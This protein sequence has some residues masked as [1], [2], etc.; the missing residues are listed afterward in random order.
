LRKESH[1]LEK[2]RMNGGEELQ[3]WRMFQGTQLGSVL[4]GIYGNKQKVN[5]PIPKKAKNAFD[6]SKH[7]F[8]PVN[9]PVVHAPQ[10]PRKTT[11]RDISNFHVPTGFHGGHSQPS[12][13]H[14]ISII[15]HRKGAAEIRAEMEEI[16]ERQRHYRPALGR[17]MG[18]S[19]KDR[20][21]QICTHK[22]G[23]ALM[24]GVLPAVSE[25][26]FETMEKNKRAQL[27]QKFRSSRK[28]LSARNTNST[29]ANVAPAPVSEAQQ[30]ASHIQSE[31]EERCSYLE[32]MQSMGAIS[33]GEIQ[34]LQAEIKQ[35]TLE[36]IKLNKE[37]GL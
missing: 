31:I 24:A 22:G 8:Q 21:A 19:E 20:F 3:N 10:D 29:Q 4:A 6:P 7:K 35:R 18:E 17:V 26:P 30:L 32:E 2:T 12:S 1:F 14:A 28:G 16:A 13:V 15:P 11:R 9:A 5:Y 36:L 23:K 37:M 25:A 33:K 34:T 27:E